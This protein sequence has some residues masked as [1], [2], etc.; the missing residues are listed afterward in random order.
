MTWLLGAVFLLAVG[1]WAAMRQGN[2]R[3]EYVLK[4]AVMVALIV[5]VITSAGVEG[6]ILWFVLGLA[7]SLVGDIFLMLPPERYFMLGLIAFLL[8]HIGYILGFGVFPLAAE[9]VIPAVILAVMISAA[10]VLIFQRLRRGLLNSGKGGMVLP[11]GAYAGVISVM[12]FSAGF[13]LMSPEWSTGEAYPAAIGGLLFYVSDVMNAWERFVAPIQN[14]RL[15]VMSTYHL[16]Q[17][18]LAVGA[19]LHFGGGL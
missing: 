13:T 5:W 19:V 14:G 12:L 2:R 16:G 18:G 1:D 15:W 6:G 8:A 4:P 10:G 9:S 17:I 7:L 11:V 3:A